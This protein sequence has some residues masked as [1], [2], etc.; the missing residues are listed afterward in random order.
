[1]MRRSIVWAVTVIVAAA[2]ATHSF[3][4]VASAR[5]DAV[6]SFDGT[7]IVLSCFP[8]EGLQPGQK[9]L[10][11]P[12]RPGLVERARHRRERFVQRSVREHG[13]GPFRQAGYNVLTWDPRGFGQSGGTVQSDSPQYER[14]AT[15]RR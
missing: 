14:A 3:A 2:L 7:R 15:C 4:P 6:T 1:M 11:H 9:A 10:H 8:A 13:R 5:D 12:D